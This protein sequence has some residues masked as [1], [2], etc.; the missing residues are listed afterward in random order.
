[1]MLE[2]IIR[3]NGTETFGCQQIAKS[4]TFLMSLTEGVHDMITNG[5]QLQKWTGEKCNE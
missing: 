4:F 3:A 2:K 5:R 1:M